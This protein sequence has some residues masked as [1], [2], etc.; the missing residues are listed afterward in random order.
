MSIL[1][2]RRQA[3][4]TAGALALAAGLPRFSF[5]GTAPRVL[6]FDNLHTGEKLRVE[7]HAAGR[8]LPDALAQ[9]NHVLRDFRSG[10][11][12]AID[13]ALLDLLH[14]LAGRLGTQK[15]FE[16]ISGYRSARTNQALREHGGGGVAKRSLHMDGRAIDVRVPGVALASVRQAALGLRQGGVGYY[17]QDGFVHVDTGRVR[18]W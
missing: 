4:R 5:A 10:E 12:G 16:V 7:Y 13:V 2:P 17:P 6:A 1:L 11:A 15:P 8:Y 3:L 14:G 18:D 9:V